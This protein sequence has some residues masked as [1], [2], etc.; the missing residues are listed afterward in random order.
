MMKPPRTPHSPAVSAACASLALVA[1]IA[2][3][4]CER[5]SGPEGDETAADSGPKVE[6][7]SPEEAASLLDADSGLVVLDVRRPDEFAEG[8]IAGAINIEFG[9]EGFEEEIAK[10]DRDQPYLLH[11]RSGNRSSQTLPVFESL[12]FR[13]LYHLDSGMIGWEKAGLPVEE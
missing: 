3:S 2:L 9:A 8:H 5:A 12:Q 6:A 1:L 11:C 13:K 10:L 4:A 7:V